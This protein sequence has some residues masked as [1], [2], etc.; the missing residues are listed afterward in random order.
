MESAID[1]LAF[2]RKK[3][4]INASMKEF[5]AKGYDEASTNVIAKEAG[6]SKAL[7]FHYVN[8]KEALFLY[9][10]HYC[11]RLIEEDYLWQLS[12]TEGDLFLRL[13]QSFTLQIALLE[14]HPWLLEFTQL[15]G[16]TKSE[17]INQVLEER[18]SKQDTFCYDRIFQDVDESHFRVGLSVE[19]C[20]EIIGLSTIGFTSQL[21]A[22][23]RQNEWQ[24]RAISRRV[25]DYLNDLRGIFYDEGRQK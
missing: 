15:T 3:A 1:K 25:A 10:F 20:K 12:F 6:L 18:D 11:E 9:V 21:L 8:S 24:S 13:E 19:R 23:I 16:T 7:M 22:A 2:E 5:S 14:Q 4:I 17:Q